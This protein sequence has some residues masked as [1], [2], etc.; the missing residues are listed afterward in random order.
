MS[1]N[2]KSELPLVAVIIPVYKTEKYLR[3]CVESVIKQNYPNLSITLVDDG[4]PDGSPQIC[5]ELA[6]QYINIHVIHKENGGLSSARNAGLDR[7]GSETK[8]ILFLDSDDTLVDGAIL[9]MVKKAEWT[10]A[11]I[12]MPDRYTKVY[13]ETGKVETA[14]HFTQACYISDPIQFALDVVLEKGRAW[15]STA[16]LYS[17]DIIKKNLVRFPDGYISE[18]I[19]F[20]LCVFPYAHGIAFYSNSTLNCLKRAGSITTTFQNGFE[21]T[22]LYIDNC[23]RNFLRRVGHDDA[24]GNEKAD[25]LLC[26]NIVVYL[27]SIMSA[28]NKMPLKEK[29]AYARRLINDERFCLILR[30]KHALPYFES[31]KVMLLM[32]MVY[33]LLNRGYNW[34]VMTLLTA[35][36]G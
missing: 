26:R 8:Y 2:I 10:K 12:V 9:G 23:V 35:L 1:E 33:F 22:I 16:L 31:R 32:K 17:A 30:K 34:A 7:L 4:S 14:L 25:A 6:A 15:R 21:G 24:E 3:E 19:V 20:N 5:D 29:W 28:R 27:I 13:E 18:D 11:D 36:P